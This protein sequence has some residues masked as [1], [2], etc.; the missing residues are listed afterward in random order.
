M[1]NMKSK[2]ITSMGL[3]ATLLIATTSFAHDPSEH[4]Q[5]NEKPNCAAMDHSN[6][7][8]ND[9]VVQAMMKQC[10]M[11]G[12]M[13]QHDMKNMHDM[14]NKHSDM[15]TRETSRMHEKK[16]M[17]MKTQKPDEHQH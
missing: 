16:S 6:M 1:K 17:D 9:P 2:M 3:A 14:K 4:M 11:G 7:D 13:K 10:S 8:M 12:N 5:D 15:D